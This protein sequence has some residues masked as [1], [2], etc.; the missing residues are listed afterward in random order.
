MI[1]NYEKNFFSNYFYFDLKILIQKHTKD[2][3]S[4]RFR[5]KNKKLNV[6]LLSFRKSTQLIQKN[7]NK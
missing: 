2:P 1:L 7:F 5:K 4:F 3:I 6:K